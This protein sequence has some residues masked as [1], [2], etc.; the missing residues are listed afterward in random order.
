MQ[1]I[2]SPGNFF[3]VVLP[4]IAPQGPILGPSG[5][6]QSIQNTTF[7]LK[8]ALLPSKNGLWERFLK[9]HEIFMKNAWKMNQKWCQQR[10]KNQGFLKR[11]L[12]NAN[13]LNA[14]K[15]NRISM[16]LGFGASSF[17]DKNQQKSIQTWGWRRHTVFHRLFLD[18]GSIL[19]SFWEP[20]PQKNRPRTISKTHWKNTRQK[21]Q[22]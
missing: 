12:K 10:T 19:A 21:G 14:I 5:G 20:K 4:K 3:G 22:L 17:G 8:F 13:S 9:K 6:R 11:F 15:H 1:R 16:I 2:F 7:E 18:I